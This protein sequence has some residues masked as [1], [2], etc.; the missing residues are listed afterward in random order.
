[1][2][3][4][5]QPFATPMTVVQGVLLAPVDGGSAVGSDPVAVGVS[6][7][8]SPGDAAHALGSDAAALGWTG[9]LSPD[10]AAH[11]VGSDAA[12]VMRWLPALTGL[13]RVTGVRDE[14]R[15]TGVPLS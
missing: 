9:A 12:T 8:V 11:G 3:V 10:G 6:Y 15:V 1:M 5:L 14:A 7:V 4:P 2:F 13:G